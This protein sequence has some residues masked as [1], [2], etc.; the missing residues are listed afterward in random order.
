MLAVALLASACGG[1]PALVPDFVAPCTNVP[2]P[3]T[4]EWPIGAVGREVRFVVPAPRV[5]CASDQSQAFVEVRDE[6]DAVV[7]A[8]AVLVS[9]FGDVRAIVSFVPARAGPHTVR[10][11]FEP[12]LGVVQGTVL[13]GVERR[14]TALRERL[15]MRADSCT[16]LARTSRGALLCIGESEVVVVRNGV[17]A[18]RFAGS[19]VF[20][21]GDVVWHRA[22]QRELMRRV[23]DGTAIEVT[24]RV[25]LPVEAVTLSGTPGDHTETFALRHWTDGL[26]WYAAIARWNGS[27]LELTS[28]AVVGGAYLMLEGDRAWAATRNSLCLGSSCTQA[29]DALVGA[30]PGGVW[31]LDLMDGVVVT[32]TLGFVRRPFSTP[33]RK[34]TWQPPPMVSVGTVM[35][36]FGGGVTLD[37][38]HGS[39]DSVLTLAEQNGGF[40]LELWPA[41][42]SGLRAITPAWI[43]TGSDDPFEVQVYP[44]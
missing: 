3:A 39:I 41:K 34:T 29:G 24:G 17:E 1:G 18:G 36:G 10:V 22:G 38:R 20:V 44:R 43:I 12:M 2:T 9:A 5:P 31:F 26:N 8:T 6:T 42:R 25:T 19:D 4:V 21:T 40:A 37:L 13:V 33:P 23:D 32:R 11:R 15:P 14:V 35:L 28:Q 7:D 16:E 30:G 27:A